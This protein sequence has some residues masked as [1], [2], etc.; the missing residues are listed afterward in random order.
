MRSF[1]S[2]NYFV[3]F[4]LFW[5]PYWSISDYW[6]LDNHRSWPT[7]WSLVNHQSDYVLPN[8]TCESSGDS[9]F[10]WRLR[11]SFARIIQFSNGDSGNYRDIANRADKTWLD[12]GVN[13]PNDAGARASAKKFSENPKAESWFT[14]SFLFFVDRKPA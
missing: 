10:Q 3:K 11:I 7:A 13:L 4:R 1:Y 14:S 6:S 12:R 5:L 2:F 9:W 8:S